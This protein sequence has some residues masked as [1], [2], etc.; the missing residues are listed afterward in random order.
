MGR[1]RERRLVSGAIAAHEWGPGDGQLVLCWHGAG[2]TGDDFAPIAARLSDELGVRVLAV[3]GPGHGRSAPAAADAFLPSRLAE[4][5]VEIV[6]DD[7]PVFVGFSWGASIACRLAV[8][9]PEHVRGLVLIEG[10]HLD[11]ADLPGFRP[12]RDLDELVEEARA[13]EAAEGAAFGR[14]APE[15]AGAMVFGLVSEP[16]QDV[17]ARLAETG[18]PVLFVGAAAS[19]LDFDPV[20]RLRRRVPQTAVARLASPSHDLLRDSPD[21]VADMMI[22][23]LR[24]LP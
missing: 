9:Y 16:V 21:L 14:F 13:A 23:W 6:G 15:T 3:D 17:Y 5:A 20:E 8:G 10:G 19:G 18:V 12:G 1:S 7:R 22:G 2:G 24:E 11:F 4:L